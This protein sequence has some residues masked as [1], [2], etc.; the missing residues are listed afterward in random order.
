MGTSIPSSY[1]LDTLLIIKSVELEAGST[2]H[3][4]SRDSLGCKTIKINRFRREGNP[5]YLGSDLHT[6]PCLLGILL[7][8]NCRGSRNVYLHGISFLMPITGHFSYFGNREGIGV[9]RV[10]SP[11]FGPPLKCVI[12]IN[13][14]KPLLP[15]TSTILEKSAA[16]Q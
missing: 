14:L 8:L 7:D 12:P 16:L 15:P 13:F 11:A 9:C 5:F 10:I 3:S 2:Q 1:N 4:G 6:T